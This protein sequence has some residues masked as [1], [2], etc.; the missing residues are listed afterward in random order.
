MQLSTSM[1]DVWTTFIFNWQKK[2]FSDLILLTK[3]R[4]PLQ[5]EM[6]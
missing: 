4:L 3:C 5:E 6:N 2:H 1:L